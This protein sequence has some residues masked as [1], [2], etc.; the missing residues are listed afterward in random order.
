MGVLQKPGLASSPEHDKPEGTIPFR[1]F[2]DCKELSMKRLCC[3]AF[4]LA[5]AGPLAAAWPPPVPGALTLTVRDTA[6]VA[7]S[8]EVVTS[9]IPL[10]R[11]LGLLA[12]ASLT[13]VDAAARPVP[14]EFHV[15]ARWNA[16]RTDAS[17]PIEWLL[18]SFPA[19]VPAGGSAVYRIVTDGSAGPN[20][21]PARPLVLSSAGNQVTVDTGAAVFTLGGNPGALFDQIRLADGTA[22]V[23]GG[24]LTARTGGS[25]VGH[26]TTRRVRIERSGPLTAVVVVEGA[27]SMA[28]V[29]GGGLG[30][31]RRYVFTAGSPTALVRHAVSWEGDRCGAGVLTCGGSPNGVRLERVRD[32]LDLGL[33]LPRS[34]QAVGAFASPAATGTV[35]S[36]Q[37]AWVRQLLRA[38]RTDPLSFQVSVPGSSPANGVKA[39]GGVLAAGTSAGAVAVALA[40]MHRFEPQAVR[41]LPDGRLALDAAD[42]PVWLGARQGL[43]AQMAVGALT[44]GPTRADLDRLVWAPLNRP[45][46]AWPTAEWLAASGAVDEF[47]AG[48]LPLELQGYDTLVSQVLDR[49]LTQIDAKGLPGLMTFG[50]Y[51]REWGLWNDEIDCAGNDPTPAEAW[52]DKYWC[53]SWTDYHNAAATPVIRALRTGEVSWL[54]ELAVP[55]ALR[56]LHT[57]VMQCAPGDTWFYC[58]QAPAG[59]GGYRADFNSSHAYFEN[60]FFYYWLTGDSTVVETLRRGASSMRDYLCS[61]RPAAPCQP[62]DPPADFWAFLTG[63]AAMQWFEVFRFVGLA[64]DASYLDDWRSGLARAATQ[65]HVQALQGGQTYGFWMY[66][67]D[68]VDGPGT[69]ATDQLWMVSLYDMNS[70]ARLERET[71]DATIGSPAVTPS[72][73]QASWARTLADFGSTAAPGGDGTASGDWPNGLFFTWSGARIGGAL[74]NVTADLGGGDPL[75]YGTGKSC[76]TAAVVRAADAT[77]DPDLAVL[78]ADLT[79]TSLSL[80]SSELQPL[81][82]IQGLYLA[83]LHTAVARLAA[84]SPPTPLDFYTVPPCRVADTRTGLPLASGESRSFPVAGLCGIPATARAVAVNLTAISPTGTGSLTVWPAGGLAPTASALN[85][86]AGQTRANNAL[87]LL[88]NDGL[89]VRPQVGGSG[90]VHLVLDVSGWFE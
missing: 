2:S 19:T 7:R 18:V 88:G 1:A 16:G 41:L 25:D 70:L 84:Q 23:T 31:L 66:G 90:T 8:G 6:G 75:L 37:E 72:G 20:P 59:Y 4:L 53:A 73:I 38:T 26:P 87:L 76:L 24:T 61:R 79:R 3:S 64:D 50:L 85:F 35:A 34:V 82:K 55:A 13:L 62:G 80:A 30:S 63:R 78:G 14:A 48:P 69:D 15:L 11:S 47:P 36:S 22:L 28:P 32:A 27:Y 74:A 58:G 43:F 57:Q 9:G 71:L 77:G 10:P 39:D 86:A 12:P 42:G 81:N 44:P 49:T 45:L 29:G 5:A 40:L 33:G 54:D 21:P 51:P 17:A 89:A 56:M 46:R 65:H 52:D 68:P 67:G 60:L 83:R